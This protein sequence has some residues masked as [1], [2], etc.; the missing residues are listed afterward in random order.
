MR[1]YYM[2][3]LYSFAPALVLSLALLFGTAVASR[4]ILQ[5]TCPITACKVA[6]ATEGIPPV[7]TCSTCKT[8]YKLTTDHT[9]CGKRAV[10]G[11]FAHWAPPPPPPAPPLPA[12]I[13]LYSS[14]QLMQLALLA[15]LV[16]G[17][18][19]NAAWTAFML[20]PASVGQCWATS[21]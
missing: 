11:G 6:C 2:A 4:D 21:K 15:V 12:C 13:G 19:T 5:T 16:S 7:W 14:V 1:S 20:Q 8:G 10:G 17:W 3:K 18:D 9:T